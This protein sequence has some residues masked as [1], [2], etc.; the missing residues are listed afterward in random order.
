MSIFILNISTTLPPQINTPN[1]PIIKFKAGLVSKA[2]SQALNISPRGQSKHLKEG[3]SQVRPEL[4]LFDLHVKDYST[5][6]VKHGGGSVMLRACFSTAGIG[7]LIN[8][9]NPGIKPV[10]TPQKI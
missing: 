1:R 7:K 4:E 3:V 8:T 9:G 5:H 6:T 2:L 10:A